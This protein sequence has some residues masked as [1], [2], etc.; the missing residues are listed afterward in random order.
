M[1]T[2]DKALQ[3]VR[4]YVD[5]LSDGEAVVEDEHTLD[6]PYGWVFFYQGREYL[7]SKDSMR[8][9]GGNAP[10]IFNRV[11]GEIRVT[12][13]A[14]PLSEYLASYESGLPPGQLMMTPQVR[15]K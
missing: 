13:T 9:L 1:W 14:Y 2:Y 12:G 11:D 10:L 15:N 8:M 5:V 6:K 7:E 4:T 3:V